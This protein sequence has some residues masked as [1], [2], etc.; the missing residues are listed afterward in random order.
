MPK[1]I[2]DEML[3]KLTDELK[4]LKAVK[5]GGEVGGLIHDLEQGI[6]NLKG[7]KGDAPVKGVDYFTQAEIDDLVE[8][9]L[10]NSE[11]HLKRVKMGYTPVKGV[12]YNDGLPGSQGAPGRDGR[13][14]KD[15][16][17]TDDKK[18][19]ADLYKMSEIKLRS[20]AG[21]LLPS[22][23]KSLGKYGKAIKEALES[24]K[25]DDRL[26]IDAI[27]D[28]REELDKIKRKPSAVI[29]SWSSAGGGKIVKS[30]DLTTV[31][32]GVTKSFSLPAFY[33]VISVHASSFPY[34][35]REN[36]DY[37]TDSNATTI[38]F[39]SE[40]EATSTLASGQTITIIYSE[41]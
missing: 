30:Y 36:V 28:L 38:T 5:D 8:M 22:I 14:G 31:L 3:K 13:D 26:S 19:L 18:I 39:T 17:N 6:A 10:A 11:H 32:N 21:S 7:E 40:I 33:R 12:D 16:R 34:S 35:F 20:L 15:G 1:K 23:E 24:L 9:V 37:T 2:D 41:A 27:K 4:R 25:G 29:G